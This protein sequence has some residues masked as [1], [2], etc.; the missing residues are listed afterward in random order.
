[1][2]QPTQ[3]A[4]TH[5]S[6]LFSSTHRQA[7][8]N[9]NRATNT[10][11]LA[12]ILTKDRVIHRVIRAQVPRELQHAQATAQATTTREAPI[13][14]QVALAAVAL[15]ILTHV[16]VAVQ[17]HLDQATHAQAVQA[18]AVQVLQDRAIHVQA[19]AQVLQDQVL[20]DRRA[21]LRRVVLH[22][23]VR[24]D[25]RVVVQVAVANYFTLQSRKNR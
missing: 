10:T 14:V 20:Q 16:Q 23:A 5:I 12:T 4:T 13:R 19:A 11:A 24:Q 25:R 6:A 22:R 18:A 3:T 21:A 17:A 15:E 7:T 2:A 9:L 8:Q 1:V